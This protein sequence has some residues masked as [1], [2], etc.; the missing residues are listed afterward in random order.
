MAG[1]KETG[2]TGQQNINAA[3][4]MPAYGG[5]QQQSPQSMGQVAEI[6]Y[7]SQPPQMLGQ[8]SMGQ[9]MGSQEQYRAN[10]PPQGSRELN[11]MAQQQQMAN[12]V[13]NGQ[14]NNR[15]NE[16]RAMYPDGLPP[17][18]ENQNPATDQR[19]QLA[20]MGQAGPSRMG[21]LR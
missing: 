20:A 1:G 4:Q 9:G 12:E 17:R 10:N 2:G 3:A 11:Q 8:P 6:G 21:P 16:R 5:Q 15:Q 7:Q 19:Q 18:G 14:V 13:R